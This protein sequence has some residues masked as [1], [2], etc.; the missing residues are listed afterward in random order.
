MSKKILTLALACL[1]GLAQTSVCAA[2]QA[3][4]EADAA[5]R[6][7]ARVERAGTGYEARIKVKMKD[8]TQRKGYVY[9]RHDAEFVLRD[10]KTDAATT[11]AY[12]DVANVE[13]EHGHSTAKNVATR[14]AIGTG[15]AVGTLFLIT[16]LAIAVGRD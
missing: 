13:I 14:A 11:I 6:A 10:T 7:R 1:V 4:K 2:S 12:A 9:E 16:L 3:A 15:V 5:D 8:G